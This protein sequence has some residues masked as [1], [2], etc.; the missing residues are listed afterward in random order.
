MSGQG[1]LCGAW[2]EDTTQGTIPT[3]GWHLDGSNFAF[4][5]G[6]V[7]WLKGSQVS[8]GQNAESGSTPNSVLTQTT[9]GASAGYAAGTSGTFSNGVAPAG[10]Y[11]IT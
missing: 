10:T 1:W 2:Q 3:S 7:K 8:P 5:D 6:H 11:S 9:T 4:L